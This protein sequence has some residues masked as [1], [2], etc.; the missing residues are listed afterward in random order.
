MKLT[1]MASE[2]QT[3]EQLFREAQTAH[4]QNNLR[5]AEQ[6]YHKVLTIQPEHTLA[7]EFLGLLR[8]QQKRFVEAETYLSLA[9]KLQPDKALLLS[10]LG[11]T[12]RLLN[13]LDLAERNLQKA[14]ALQPNLPQANLNLGLTKLALKQYLE[15]EQ[16]FLRALSIKPEYLAAMNALSG[17]YLQS[18][19]AQSALPYLQRALELGGKDPSVWS[20][21]GVAYQ[22]LGNSEQ[23]I[24][25]WRQA[26]KLKPNYI[27]ALRPAAEHEQKQGNWPQAI[28]LFQN[29]L[30]QE[31]KSVKAWKSLAYCL[32]KSGQYQTV[33]K[34]LNQ[35]LTYIP[36]SIDLYYLKAEMCQ[37]LQKFEL[38][39]A[40]FLEV[41]K[42]DPH[43]LKCLH[44]LALIFEQQGNTHQAH[45]YYQRL[46]KHYPNCDL[47]KLHIDLL[48]PLIL[49][50]LT[51]VETVE[52][53]L[54]TTLD[55]WLAKGLRFKYSDLKFFSGQTNCYYTYFT[56]GSAREF[57]EKLVRL[58]RPH[59][60]RF[61][62]LKSS[63]KA[64]LGFVVTKGHEG[65][66]IR[67]MAKSLNALP[68]A[69]YALTIFADST[70][71]QKKIAPQVTHA[72]IEHIE[73]PT[74]IQ[75]SAEIIY[76]SACDILFF[77]ENGTDSH[78]FF[79]PFFRLAP[80]QMHTG[81]PLSSGNSEMDYFLVNHRDSVPLGDSSQGFSEEILYL[82]GSIFTITKPTFP[83]HFKSKA[84]LGLPEHKRIYFCAQNLLKMHPD[85]D[86]AMLHILDQDPDAVIVLAE[87]RATYI[88]QILQNRLKQSCQKVYERILFLPRLNYSDYLNVLKRSD[89]IL[90]P[91]HYAGSTTTQEAIL[92]GTLVINLPTPHL[93]GRGTLILY[94][95]LGITDSLAKDREDYISKVAFY[96]KN[97]QARSNL[98]QK[99]NRAL[100]LYLSSEPQIEKASIDAYLS[101]IET[102]IKEIKA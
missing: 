16:L 46:L 94:N 90:D 5:I 31:P 64:H 58:F 44:A 92:A 83:E 51:A 87:H 84:D 56:R 67:W 29:W 11:E 70:G 25:A 60:P 20:N 55:T 74:S 6:G 86:G 37:Q 17:L 21:L 42:R 30:N 76:H 12:Q 39:E 22:Q 19:Q 85:F 50:S 28:K 77:W 18:K 54:H 36:D 41:F 38:A 63:G 79:L 100:A 47:L 65:I 23:A 69:K 4:K 33:L 71:F 53:Q 8:F 34:V 45:D 48:T 1:T 3:T 101:F 95:T 14:C 32:K 59:L 13:K 40:A 88:T 66:F 89:L 52:S 99:I 9:A 2:D 15:A 78:N 80:V 73:I 72:G 27:F 43:N 57:R 61:K 35:A 62:P 75:R 96:G 81:W 10:N 98:L 93:R 82:P 91:F 7:Q 97:T 102:K 68:V 24:S 49:P 26:L